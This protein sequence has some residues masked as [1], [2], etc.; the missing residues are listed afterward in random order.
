M[1]FYHLSVVGCRLSGVDVIVGCVCRGACSLLVLGCW[2]VDC[3]VSMSVVFVGSCVSGQ[4][5]VLTVC[6]GCQ[7]FF[8]LSLLSSWDNQDTG[9]FAKD[10]TVYWGTHMEKEILEDHLYIGENRP[11]FLGWSLPGH[12]SAS[13]IW[14]SRNAFSINCWSKWTALILLRKI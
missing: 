1:L 6:V 10:N 7:S 2:L 3:Q 9:C 14:I 4:L 12:H 5:L 8:S 13:T 11:C